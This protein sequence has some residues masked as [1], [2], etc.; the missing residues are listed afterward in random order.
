MAIMDDDFISNELV[1]YLSRYFPMT[2]ELARI[3]LARS[4]VKRFPK[5][6]I[7][8]KQGDRVS[9]TYFILSGCI[10]SYVIKNGDDKTVDFFIEGDPI[11]PMGQGTDTRATHFLECSEDT[12]A[13]TSNSAQEE[14]ALAE[15]PQ[16]KAICLAMSET[17]AEKLQ[18]TLAR[19]RTS[20]PEERYG[21]L[22][23]KRP[24]LLR[25]IPQYQ[26]ASYLGVKPESLSRI[27]KR[28]LG[29]KKPDTGR[30]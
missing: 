27:R 18:D 12:L 15:H 7:L 1:S 20:T 5:G 22:V 8:L 21:E 30:Y 25:R 19:Y 14:K 11:L 10:R 4:F 9:D 26:I 28:L 6:T 29:K 24:D 2:D 17:M 16:L 23:E 3:F 13:I